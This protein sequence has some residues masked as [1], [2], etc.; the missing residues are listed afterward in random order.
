[1]LNGS[2][3][4]DILNVKIFVRISNSLQKKKKSSRCLQI[5]TIKAQIEKVS[6]MKLTSWPNVHSKHHP[7]QAMFSN[8]ISASNYPSLLSS[9]RFIIRGHFAFNSAMYKRSSVRDS[10]VFSDCFWSVND[11]FHFTLLTCK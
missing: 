9:K 8:Q 6:S 1:M 2:I 11:I 3:L 4:H 7:K 5:L 10:L